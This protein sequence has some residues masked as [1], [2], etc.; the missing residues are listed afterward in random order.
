MDNRV[1]LGRAGDCW[2]GVIE[3]G[4]KGEGRKEEGMEGRGWREG[5][6]W[7]KAEGGLSETRTRIKRASLYPLRQERWKVVVVVDK[8]VGG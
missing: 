1:L 7:R 6:C 5:N 2:K 4:M 3:Q 8:V